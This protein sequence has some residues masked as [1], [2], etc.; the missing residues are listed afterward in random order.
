MLFTG[1]LPLRLIKL[2]LYVIL[3]SVFILFLQICPVLACEYGDHSD[4]QA[5]SKNKKYTATV[6]YSEDGI[7]RYEEQPIVTLTDNST[8][9]VLWSIAF[10]KEVKVFRP[11][12]LLVTNDGYIVAW[13]IDDYYTFDKNG[14]YRFAFNIIGALN[15]LNEKKLFCTRT[16]LDWSCKEF[17]TF[18]IFIYNNKEYYYLS[19]YWGRV[20]V[21]DIKDGKPATDQNILLTTDKK[22]INDTKIAIESYSGSYIGTYK[23]NGN[24]YFHR[25]LYPFLFT[26][27]KYSINEGQELLNIFMKF[28]SNKKNSARKIFDKIYSN[29]QLQP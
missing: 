2:P 4:L 28:T 13:G 24:K 9:S 23:I 6:D 3:S 15:E 29:Y 26:T 1:I 27:R 10:P 16:T 17:S 14:N 20:F 19:L 5:N 8:K 18:G 7:K 12:H 21:I 11:Y 22:I 25:E